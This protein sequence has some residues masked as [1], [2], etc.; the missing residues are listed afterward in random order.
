MVI[1]TNT[2][3]Y[4]HFFI[5]PPHQTSFGNSH[6]HEERA[7]AAGY[8]NGDLK[9]F[10][11]KTNQL[12]WESN[13]KNGVC[14]LEFDRKDIVMNKLVATTLEGRF[15]PFDLRTLHT[16][17]GYAELKDSA[18]KATVWGVKHLPQN[19]DIFALQ[20][21]N[22]AINLYK[23]HYPTERSIKDSEGRQRGVAGTVELLNSRDFC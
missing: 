5:P 4:T 18:F 8:D 19:R 20:G 13:L 3:K 9:W 7:I 15:H 16:E 1:S 14:G 22:G 12:L 17:A 2:C 10:D 6:N 11:L 21:G 23:Y